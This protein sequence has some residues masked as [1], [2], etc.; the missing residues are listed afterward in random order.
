MRRRA[1]VTPLMGAV[2]DASSVQAAYLVPASCFVSIAVYA[3]LHARAR[4]A[5]ERSGRLAACDSAA[6]AATAAAASDS[7]QVGRYSGADAMIA[8]MGGLVST[9]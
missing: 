2:S 9:T 4:H 5:V 6:E 1:L 3:R 7:T 8:R